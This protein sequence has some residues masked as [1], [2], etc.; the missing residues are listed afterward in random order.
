MKSLCVVCV[1]IDVSLTATAA[2]ARG[3]MGGLLLWCRPDSRLV[4]IDCVGAQ[5]R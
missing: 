1:V 5:R 3:G 2:F 4:A